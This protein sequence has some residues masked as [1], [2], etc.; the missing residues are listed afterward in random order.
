LAL[1]HYQE[2]GTGD[3]LIALHPLALES[4][5]CAGVARE[6]SS[7]GLRT[8][9][10]DL[11]G[12]GKSP[13]VDGP[14]TPAALAEPVIELARGLERPPIVMG[15][16]LGGRVAIEMALSA[17][18]TVRGLVLVAPYMPWLRYH[19]FTKLARHLDP[20]WS[21]RLP[22]ERMW[23]LLKRT[24]DLLEKIPALEH[25]WFARACVR[26]AYYSTCP[27]TRTA[28]LSAARELAL[29]PSAGEN[30]LWTRISELSMPVS[31]LWAGRD[32][33]IPHSHAAEVAKR[34]PDASQ[35]EVACSGHFVNFVHHRCMEHAI[36]LAT[37]RIF[38]AEQTREKDP[39]TILTPCIAHR[40][41]SRKTE[42]PDATQ[43]LSVLNTRPPY[44]LRAFDV[45]RSL[46]R[47]FAPRV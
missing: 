4:T 28:F 10:V 5:A 12:F 6:L 45:L 20:A 25:D 34:M 43:H 27:D 41:A 30:G 14:L 13:L 32:R 40:E 31:F 38:D 24:T 39:H 42:R 19:R 44:V 21:E 15:M 8:L 36:T 9:A 26:V 47:R 2:W 7:L 46:L 11:P 22:L 37:S 1:L 3:P 33:V 23:P 17:P 16:S 18:E 29:D 35:L